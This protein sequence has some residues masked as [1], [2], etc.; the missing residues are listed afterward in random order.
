MDEP[1]G[2]YATV[3]WSLRDKCCAIPI[4]CDIYLIKIM[5]QMAQLP[6][7]ERGK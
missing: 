4:A 7:A 6:G 5:G 1:W 2:H 3:V